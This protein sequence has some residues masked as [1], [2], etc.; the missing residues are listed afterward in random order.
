[1]SCHDL[2]RSGIFKTLN[3]VQDHPPLATQVG[4]GA[5]ARHI[6]AGWHIALKYVYAAFSLH[7]L[8]FDSDVVAPDIF[9]SSPVHMDVQ[10]SQ[11]PNQGGTD[12]IPGILWLC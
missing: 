7:V 2:Y 12:K 5:T 4:V 1:M 9:R 10:Y 3:G 6:Y 11:T 8:C